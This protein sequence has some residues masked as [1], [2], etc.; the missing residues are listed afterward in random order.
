L[1]NYTPQI[2]VELEF[3]LTQANQQI[4]DSKIIENFIIN[5]TK[6][7]KNQESAINLLNIEK[8]KGL[9]QIEIKTLPY[10]DL[11]KLTTDLNLIKK[12]TCELALKYNF[13]ANF[14]PAPFIND[15]SNALQI[16]LTL[17]DEN[18]KNIFIKNQQNAESPILLNIIGAILYLLPKEIAK[19]DKNY[20]QSQRFNLVRNKEL[21]KIGKYTSPVNL[22]WG[23]DNRT[24]AIR[25]IGNN[26]DRRLEFRVF[27]A[28]I[29]IEVALEIFLKM[30]KYGLD[31]K[32]IELIEPIYG[33]AF[34]SKFNNKTLQIVKI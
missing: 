22:S 2:G 13:E 16:N 30:M 25:I 34:E 5:L 1:P 12:I 23:Y 8:E 29:N 4:A 7:I 24:C 21:F 14:E 11:K 18:Q 33:N 3:Y 6:I 15:C 28:N 32:K 20:F 9:G 17:L 26:N 19:I 31:N 27:N 10:L